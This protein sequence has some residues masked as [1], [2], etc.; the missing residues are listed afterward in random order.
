MIESYD[1]VKVENVRLDIQKWLDA[2]K[3]YPEQDSDEEYSFYAENAYP[4]ADDRRK[5]F[6]HLVEGK[7]P[8]IGYHLIAMLA[9]HEF[10]K[11]IWTTNFDGFMLKCEHQ[12]KVTPIEV[13]LESVDRIYR[14]D[15][16]G[17]YFV[18][19]YMVIINMGN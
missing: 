14:N 6:Q 3:I 17:K 8:S 9:E 18:L 5:Y 11:S 10:L 13:T 2:Q 7:N 15:V 19:L 16:S 1:N 12:Y 4:I